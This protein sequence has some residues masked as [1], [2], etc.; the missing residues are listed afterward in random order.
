MMLHKIY[1][2]NNF[3]KLKDR[4]DLRK[5]ILKITEN[6]NYLNSIV[7]LKINFKKWI[8]INSNESNE[9]VHNG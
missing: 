6:V 5:K 4:D 2:F 8:D 9:K 7:D 3:K 1:D